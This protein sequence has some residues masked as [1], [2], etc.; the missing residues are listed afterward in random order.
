MGGLFLF[1]VYTAK[2]NSPHLTSAGLLAKS[3]FWRL[4][5]VFPLLLF[6]V[7]FGMRYDVGT[8]HLNYLEA[9]LWK[10]HVGKND[11]LF[12]LLSEIG[13]KLNLHYAVYFAIIAFIQVFFFFYAFKDERYL[14]P[15]LVFFLFTNGEWLN[16]M[17]VIRQSLAMCIWIFSLKYIEEKKFLKYLLWGIVAFFFH[18]S[19]IILLV[20][21]PILRNGKDYFKSIPL[22]L[23]LI[24]AAFAF[25]VLFS[26]I[27]IKFEPIIA[28]YMN[29]LGGDLYRS[30]DMERL[31][32][33]YKES[34]GTGLAYLFKIIL[35][36]GII[37]YSKKLKLFY[38]SKRF[39]IVYFFFII[40]II[41]TYMFPVGFI[42]FTRPFRYFYI[43]QSIMYAYFLYY[44]YKTKI[45]NTTY[46][47]THALIYYGLIV[48]FLGVFYLSI[49]TSNDDNSFWYQFY[50]DQNING[51]PR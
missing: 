13:W 20:F 27:I 10:E 28:Y 39:N 16:W 51:Y 8:D 32:S 14:F 22:Q 41:T 48:I 19:A 30:Y 18:K 24:A 50:F 5:T 9:Y 4:E 49:I 35:N 6:A 25:Q 46:G 26:G 7:V 21:Y 2:R 42:S 43:F 12:N 15:F 34:T 47:T 29:L 11:I 31:M 38:N 1:A 33:S 23:I 45:K 37:L 36:V 44:L 17:N 40:G 3:S